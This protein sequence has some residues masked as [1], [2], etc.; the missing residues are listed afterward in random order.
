MDGERT[1]NEKARAF[2]FDIDGV[3]ADASHRVHFIKQD[4]PDW[5]S[6]FKDIDKYMPIKAGVD[7][8]YFL[9]RFGKILFVTGRQEK[10]RK[11]TIDW[12]AYNLGYG[13]PE[14]QKSFINEHL[15]MRRTGDFRPDYI[16]KEEI[17]KSHIEPFYEINCAFEDRKQCV[18]M[19]RKLGITCWQNVDGNY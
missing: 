13:S 15:Y 2:I 5:D 7:M 18:D 17:Y 9:Y 3:L 8:V 1:M 12:L 14:S 10:H 6:F 19:W 11:E 4:P 16:V